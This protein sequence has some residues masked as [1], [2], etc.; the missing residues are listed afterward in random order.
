MTDL[1][2]ALRHTLDGRWAA[3]REQIR[4]EFEPERFAPPSHELTME[5]YRERVA[6][7]V[8]LIAES[9]HLVHHGGAQEVEYAAQRL[10]FGPLLRR[11]RASDGR[12]G[13]GH[14]SQH[15]SRTVI[16]AARPEW[17]GT[18]RRWSD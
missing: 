10:A 2:T 12:H 14:R 3:V 15:I 11:A 4:G 17:P 13:V 5:E 8:Q 9:G 7:Q 18:T 1:S 16:S 6:G